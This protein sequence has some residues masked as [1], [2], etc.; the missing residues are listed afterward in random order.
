MRELYFSYTTI[1]LY[2]F[3]VLITVLITIILK[4][5]WSNHQIVFLFING[6]NNT[7]KERTYN[8]RSK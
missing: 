1:F 4:F 2:E 3:L 6:P 8:K 7:K 5:L